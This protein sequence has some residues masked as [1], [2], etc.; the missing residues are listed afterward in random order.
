MQAEDLKD[1]QIRTIA[2]D[3][4]ELVKK[5]KRL[6]IEEVAKTLKIPLSSTESLVNFMVEE[7]ILGIEY[8]FTTPYIYLYNEEVKED[9]TKKFMFA[10]ELVIKETFYKHAKEKNIPDNH[11]EELWRK[12]IRE[13]IEGIR[14]DFFA[15]SKEK[16]MPQKKIEEIWEKY[17]LHL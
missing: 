9:E 5:N 16:K 12:Y 7:K 3:I 6:S 2:D 15:K 10:P 13:N 17:L 11:I 8:R 14:E 4:L 1:K